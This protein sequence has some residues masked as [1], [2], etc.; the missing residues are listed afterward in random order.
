[1]HADIFDQDPRCYMQYIGKSPNLACI[2]IGICTLNAST[3]YWWLVNSIVEMI[4]QEYEGSKMDLEDLKLS[5]WKSIIKQ[6]HEFN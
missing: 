5:M 2:Y 6:G 4:D 3:L 1:M